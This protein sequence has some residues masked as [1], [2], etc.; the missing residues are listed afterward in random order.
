[1]N[2]RAAS[3][4][5]PPYRLTRD[6]PHPPVKAE[7]T[8]PRCARGILTGRA[9]SVPFIAVTTGPERTATD[10]ARA[11]STWAASCFRR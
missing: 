11:I 3:A 5:W 4:A 2:C 6:G 10:N 9:T 7:L 8:A 1:M